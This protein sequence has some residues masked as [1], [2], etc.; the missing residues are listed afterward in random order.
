M[1]LFRKMQINLIDNYR[2]QYYFIKESDVVTV[3]VEFMF[4]V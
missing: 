3:G 4:F 2:K 1:N